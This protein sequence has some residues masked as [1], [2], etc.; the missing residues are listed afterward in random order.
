M[1]ASASVS[2]SKGA[3]QS[4]QRDG[5]KNSRMSGSFFDTM[6]KTSKLKYFIY[7]IWGSHEGRLCFRD[8]ITKRHGGN[9]I[10]GN[11]GGKRIKIPGELITERHGDYLVV[12]W[13]QAHKN[14]ENKS[15]RGF[16]YTA[17]CCASPAQSCTYFQDFYALGQ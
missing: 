15:A 3:S 16:V 4:G 7:I 8:N 11:N 6:P 13:D 5:K 1:P 12:T 9:Y 10:A 14:P 2:L 17:R